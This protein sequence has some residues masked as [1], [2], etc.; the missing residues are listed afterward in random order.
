MTTPE[1]FRKTEKRTFFAHHMLLNVA[2]IAIKDAA[3]AIKDAE[4]SEAGRFNKCLT[5]VVMSALAVEALANAVGL[6]V[7]K[8]WPKFKKFEKMSP[9]KKIDYLAEQ[10][11]ITRDPQQEP[12]STLRHI[13]RFRNRIAHPKPKDVK[14]D[15]VLPEAGLT[16]TAFDTP[17]SK[18]EQCV[19]LDMALRSYDAVHTLKGL[20]TD[21]L[22]ETDRFGI[23][24]DMWEGSVDVDTESNA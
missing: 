10:L 8:D 6:R 20:L 1:L 19:T 16:K 2:A 9:H 3:I 14:S 17:L 4:A 12:W 22:P 15:S 24:A 11:T 13:H 5:A 18:F 7:E 23:Y 21:A